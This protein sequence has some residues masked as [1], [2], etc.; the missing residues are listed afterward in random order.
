MVPES[1]TTHTTSSIS[2]THNDVIKSNIFR[3]TVPLWEES[4]RRRALM[5]SLIRARTNGWANNW[6][7][8]DLICHRAHYNVNEW[9]S[10][11]SI[12]NKIM[13][14][15]WWMVGN[16]DFVP[17]WCRVLFPS[18]KWNWPL[19]SCLLRVVCLYIRDIIYL[20]RCKYTFT[21]K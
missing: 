18:E 1:P 13:W 8:G 19:Y 7:A 6:H 15:N 14:Y 9:T 12:F 16:I 5:F 10:V 17:P 3:V 21:C 2:P 11:M 4:T 20:S